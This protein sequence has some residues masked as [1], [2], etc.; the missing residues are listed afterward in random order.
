VLS[1]D[2]DTPVGTALEA[3]SAL[4]VL[5][6]PVAVRPDSVQ[7]RGRVHYGA[8]EVRRRWPSCARHLAD[9]AHQRPG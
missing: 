1:F 4:K 2:H 3:L 7:E 5:S 6:A 9:E 8:R